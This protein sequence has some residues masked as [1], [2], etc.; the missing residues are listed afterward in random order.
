LTKA[1]TEAHREGEAAEHDW[2]ESQQFKRE[3]FNKNPEF[4][5][6]PQEVTIMK[7]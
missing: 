1:C 5:E 6:N 3:N 4:A 7:C 2:K